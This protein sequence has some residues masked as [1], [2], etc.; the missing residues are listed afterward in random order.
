VIDDV[1]MSP[2][3]TADAAET[4]RRLIV[5]GETGIVHVTNE[6]ACSWYEFARAIFSALN[7]ETDLQPTT[8]TEWPSPARR[9]S[10]S[11]LDSARLAALGIHLPSW[12]EGLRRYL[13]AK[14]HLD[15]PIPQ[16]GGDL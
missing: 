3:A 7:V 2:T 12:H 10:M 15:G 8:S 4:I 14:G 9:P 16:E 13:V 6:G 11:A 5:S 1:V